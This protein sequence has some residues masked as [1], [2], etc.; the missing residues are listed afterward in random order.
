MSEKEPK[1]LKDYVFIKDIGEGNFGKV[2]LSKLIST[3]EMF[4]IKILNK[5]KL[6][7]QTKTSSINEIEI[8]SKLNHPNIIHVEKILEDEI[9]YYI[10]M[11]YCS[12]GELFDYIVKLEKLDEIEA[13]T[14]FYQLII[15]VEYIHN[16]KLAHRDLK[17]ENL[18]LTKNHLL[19]IIDFGL[20]HDFD[21]T[22]LLK[23]KCGSPSYAAPEILKGFPYNGF[24]SDIWC[25]GIILYGML[26]GYLPFDGDNNQEIFRQIVQCNPE[27][28]PFLENDSIDLLSK[29]LNDE[30]NDRITIKQIKEHSFFIKGKYYYFM[31]YKENGELREES[32]IRSRSNSNT[33][34]Q[35]DIID[36]KY[37]NKKQ[38]IYST[39]KKQKD[40]AILVNNY[41]TLTKK[42]NRKYENNIYKNIFTTI[43]YKEEINNNKKRRIFLLNNLDENENNINMKTDKGKKKN[44]N[45]D[46]NNE[47]NEFKRH[48]EIKEQKDSLFLKTFKSKLNEKKL[49]LTTNNKFFDNKNNDN[50]TNFQSNSSSKKKELN[51]KNKIH[52]DI[53]SLNSTKSSEKRPYNRMNLIINNQ[54]RLINKYD[55][56]SFKEWKDKNNDLDFLQNFLSNKNKNNKNDITIKSPEKHNNFNLNLVLTKTKRN[57]REK[58][59]SERKQKNLENKALSVQ[60]IKKSYSQ[61][62]K[63]IINF[64]NSPSSNIK[65]SILKKDKFNLVFNNKENIKLKNNEKENNNINFMDKDNFS[66]SIKKSRK[67]SNF[68]NNKNVKLFNLNTKGNSV[69]KNNKNLF[70]KTN[71]NYRNESIK[72]IILK[73]NI[74]KKKNDIIQTEPKSNQFLEKVIK[75]MYTKGKQIINNNINIITFNNNFGNDNNNQ[76]FRMLDIDQEDRNNNDIIECPYL[77]NKKTITNNENN[78]KKYHIHLN[79]DKKLYLL[80]NPKILDNN[81]LNSKDKLK[82]IFP[83]LISHNK[84]I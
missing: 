41:K 28:P 13:A 74:M 83:N 2:K 27:Y 43:G 75:K 31:K 51:N 70:I 56:N 82:R 23:T 45:A 35:E 11:E 72:E 9:N 4:A 34:F 30:P 42:H 61:K 39:I 55:K 46:L 16:Q 62:K 12:D 67:S 29:I 17:P 68:N 77:I 25:C 81:R 5:E 52:F 59:L 76:V 80:K 47:M 44:Q 21:G 24:K 57:D 50:N 1:V 3:N 38:Y 65:N 64:A 63:L 69:K 20:C 7:A 6:K 26:C 60:K 37:N 14:F 15:G 79:D 53:Y 8:L 84:N 33:S 71:P 32:I 73:N 49:K 36:S 10:I 66:Y 40:N 78:N 54:K 22:K 58:I 18:L 19:K 48:N